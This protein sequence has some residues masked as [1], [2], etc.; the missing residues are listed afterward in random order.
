[1]GDLLT[2]AEY[3]AIAERLSLPDLAFIDG[4]FHP[5]A[6]SEKTIATAD[7]A[8]GEALNGIV[9]SVPDDI[10]LAVPATR[11]AS[12]D[13]YRSRLRP[14]KRKVTLPRQTEPIADHAWELGGSEKLRQRRSGLR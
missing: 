3:T 5:P 12:E 4:V 7:Q 9:A 13:G 11:A 6:P 10:G 14:A 8:T 1:M 2:T